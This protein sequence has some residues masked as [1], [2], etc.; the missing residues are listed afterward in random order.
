MGLVRL[1]LDLP[2][3][4]YTLVTSCLSVTQIIDDQ[5]A[6]IYFDLAF[7]SLCTFVGR[8]GYCY[9]NVL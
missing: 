9:K 6:V 1:C 8:D 5:V 4:A 7:A 2:W 3:P